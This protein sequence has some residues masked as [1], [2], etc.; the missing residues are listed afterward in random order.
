MTLC[1]NRGPGIG[2]R[3]W[4]ESSERQISRHAQGFDQ[5]IHEHARSQRELPSER[6]QDE[7]RRREHR[8]L[9]QHDIQSS[10]GKLVLD[11]DA[12]EGVMPAPFT[13]ASISDCASSLSKGPLGMTRVTSAKVK[14]LR[15]AT[16][17][18]AEAG[19]LPEIVDRPRNSAALK[20]FRRCAQN[21]LQH[22]QRAT[23]QVCVFQFSNSYRE[24]E[25]LANEIDTA[26]GEIELDVWRACQERARRCG[27]QRTSE[28]TRHG[29]PKHAT[30]VARRPWCRHPPGAPVTSF[31]SALT[32][33]GV[34]D[35]G[36]R[37]VISQIP[38]RT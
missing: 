38:V 35:A 37:I 10:G 33:A 28:R 13:T 5:K 15:P 6:V 29:D 24:V 1:G 20:V 21:I 22:A 14:C 3:F 36:K 30:Y 32:D 27:D 23:N 11:R 9:R 34:V 12:H 7:D 17:Q 4:S 8:Y 2:P 19:M 25:T 26:V 31:A 18:V 16:G